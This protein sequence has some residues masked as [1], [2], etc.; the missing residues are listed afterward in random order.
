MLKIG[1]I[2]MLFDVLGG[3]YDIR[4]DASKPM[5]IYNNF[6]KLKMYVNAN[7][8]IMKGDRP[9]LVSPLEFI[10]LSYY[11]SIIKANLCLCV[12]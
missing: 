6:M 5:T 9:S 8:A 11:P 10:S 1:S 3:G 7:L 12:C 2:K 4:F